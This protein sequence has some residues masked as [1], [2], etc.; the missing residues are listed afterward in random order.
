MSPGKADYFQRKIERK[1][2]NS[3]FSSQFTNEK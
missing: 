3:K 2:E 1:G